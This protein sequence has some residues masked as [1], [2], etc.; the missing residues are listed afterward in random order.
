MSKICT[1]N[2]A[3]FVP[4]VQLQLQVLRFS[5]FSLVPLP[6]WRIFERVLEYQV[7]GATDVMS[8]GNTRQSNIQRSSTL[9]D[10]KKAIFDKKYS[11]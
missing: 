1:S 6:L 10:L 2:T 7:H 3:T 5:L 4:L 8:H 9:G 11:N